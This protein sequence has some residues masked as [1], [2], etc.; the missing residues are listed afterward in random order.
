MSYRDISTHALSDSGAYGLIPESE[1]LRKIQV[2]PTTHQEDS[3]QVEQ[4]M[5]NLMRDFTPDKPF[6]ASDEPRNPNDRGGGTHSKEILDLRYSGKR[7]TEEPYL[8]DGTFTD[9]EFTELDPRGIASTPDMRQHY[10]QQVARASLIKFYNDEDWSVPEQGINPV[11]MVAN[12][13]SGFYQY[14]DRYRNF[15]ES[16]D[17]WHNGGPTRMPRVGGSDVNKTELTGDILDLTDASVRNRRDATSMLSNDPKVGFRYTVPDQRFKTARYGLVRANQDKSFQD[18]DNNRK[19]TFTDHANLAI[20]DGQQV[21]RMLG[22]LIH[23]LES[24]RYNKQMVAEGAAY[25]DSSVNQ[26]AR[27]QLDPADIYKILRVGGMTTQDPT[28]NEAFEGKMIRQYGNKPLNNN[29]LTNQHIQINHHILQSMEQATKRQKVQNPEDFTDLRNNIE[30]SAKHLG[31]F[32]VANNSKQR[33]VDSLTANQAR[34]VEDLR[35]LEESKTIKNYAGIKPA[36]QRNPHDK[37]RYEKYGQHSLQTQVRKGRR[38]GYGINTP[39]DFENDIDRGRLDF[40]VYNKATKVEP[41]DHMGRNQYELETDGRF[42]N[43]VN[44]IEMKAWEV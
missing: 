26:V 35:I 38:E 33:V 43:E 25:G 21:N 41:R 29:H 28:A 12:I 36:E 27:K 13:K 6:L 19:S 30:E 8:P 4:Y 16:F 11:D 32:K 3:S 31:V 15:D 2:A 34:S 37:L 20:I 42:E 5:R 40:G 14:K 24:R 44:E 9:F 10:E 18:W 7:S 17:S 23:D 1:Y 39:Y 22:D